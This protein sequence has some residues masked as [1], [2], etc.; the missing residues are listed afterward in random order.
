MDRLD[1]LQAECKEKRDFVNKRPFI[2]RLLLAY[3][4]T[5]RLG[6]LYR[7]LFY[8]FAGATLLTLSSYKASDFSKPAFQKNTGYELIGV[9][10]LFMLPMIFIRQLAII[11]DRQETLQ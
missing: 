6:W 4:P 5:T 1:S 9:A 11:A 10:A 8:M 2:Q 7:L 3:A